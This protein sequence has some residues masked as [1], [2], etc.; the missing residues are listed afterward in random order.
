MRKKVE[1]LK[2]HADFTAKA[3]RPLLKTPLRH[4]LVTPKLKRDPRDAD[5]PLV[6][7]LKTVQAAEKSR[8]SGTRRADQ[9]GE[10]A[11]AEDKVNA[12]KHKVFAEGFFE[13]TH[14]NKRFHGHGKGNVS[15]FPR[16]IFGKPAASF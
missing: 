6:H 2:D 16:S 3:E 5:S 1:V 12:A 11:F 8:L 4:P 13:P 10:L 14:F 7:H 9:N 15:G